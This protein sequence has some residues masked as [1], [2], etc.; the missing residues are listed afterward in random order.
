MVEFSKNM[1]LEM[2][3]GSK[4][5]KGIRELWAKRVG[6]G[7]GLQFFFDSGKSVPVQA[8]VEPTASTRCSDRVEGTQNETP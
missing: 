2:V 3:T 5:E 4:L 8:V 7:T 6:E 1:H